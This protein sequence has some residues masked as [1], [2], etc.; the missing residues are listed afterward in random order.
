MINAVNF[1]LF[2]FLI[3]FT[4][5][6]FFCLA[7]RINNTKKE[8][9]VNYQI[10][11]LYPL[12]GLFVFGET[13]LI[14]N[15]F[16][17]SNNFVFFIALIGIVS[18]IYFSNFKKESFTVQSL[19]ALIFGF[20][21]NSIDF[22][23]DAGLYH[24]N[25]QAW[26]N[27][28]KISFGLVNLHSRYGYSS[29]IDYIN[30]TTWVL[31]N[32]IYQHFTN[33]I[34]LVS[35]FLFIYISIFKNKF[36]YFRIPFIVLLGFG[37]LD[38]FGLNGGRNGFFDIEAISKQD[39]PF[40]VLFVIL[41]IYT[42]QYFLVKESRNNFN[43][44][45]IIFLF[46]FS[47][48]MRLFALFLAPLVLY[49]LIKEFKEYKKSN[50][51][52]NYLIIFSFIGFNW[53]LKNFI[54][55]SCF[56]YPISFTCVTNTNWFAYENAVVE[57]YALQ[58]FHIVWNPLKQNISG[59]LFSWMEREVN[60]TV[61]INFIGSLLVT[62]IFLFLFSSK[63]KS[64]KSFQ[65]FFLPL[66]LFFC[67]LISSPSIR[68]GISIFVISFFIL[69]LNRHSLNKFFDK[70]FLLKILFWGV[71]LSMPRL[72]TYQD[73][74]ENPFTLN[75][76]VPQK[77]SYIPHN[78]SIYWGVTSSQGDQCWININCVPGPVVINESLIFDY[79]VFEKINK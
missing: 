46:I 37:F 42:I 4:G 9:Y 74:L 71:I 31:D 15:F 17:S 33:I 2:Y 75:Y 59:W 26:L 22:S 29:F 79:R 25:T 44:I 21:S 13:K 53:I 40:A 69:G 47:V 67:W 72:S 27:E 38:N 62:L 65:Y 23:Y 8:S 35:I 12:I 73:I 34:F 32:F 77:V 60:E 50:T 61:L 52:L 68:M 19:I 6:G 1:V 51:F 54:V 64:Q 20:S 70:S 10:P 16:T 30:S 76:V 56:F 7:L 24:L 55:S 43:L 57:T 5:R 63:K 28:S 36:S 78:N 49:I 39:N 18:N 3:Y 58:S 66:Y 45:I 11:Y 41:L 48:Q 14:L